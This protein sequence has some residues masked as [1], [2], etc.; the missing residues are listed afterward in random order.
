MS[1]TIDERNPERQQLLAA[2]LNPTTR[3]V[4]ARLP[5]IPAAAAGR[6][7]EIGSPA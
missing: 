3:E 2:V 6:V 5:P 4:L 1:Y 7:L